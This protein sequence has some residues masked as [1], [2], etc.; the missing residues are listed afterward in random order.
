[1]DLTDPFFARY[2]H[3]LNLYRDQAAAYYRGEELRMGAYHAMEREQY[4][5]QVSRELERSPQLSII[6]HKRRI[7]NKN[8]VE[9]RFYFTLT[10]KDKKPTPVKLT[11]EISL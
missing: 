6:F 11:F 10:R 4:K 5:G 3:K 2:N 8:A 7:K 1:M 9:G